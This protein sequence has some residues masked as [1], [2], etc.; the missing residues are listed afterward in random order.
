MWCLNRRNVLENFT[1]PASFPLS[2]RKSQKKKKKWERNSLSSSFNAHTITSI[3]K[4]SRH[5]KSNI[6]AITVISI[7]KGPLI[8]NQGIELKIL[9]LHCF[10]SLESHFVSFF[11][12]DFRARNSM[13]L[14]ECAGFCFRES[15][16]CPLLAT[17]SSGSLSVK[18]FNPS[19]TFCF[20]FFT[21]ARVLGW[22]AVFVWFLLPQGFDEFWWS[23]LL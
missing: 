6:A 3:W 15:V 16:Q 23:L 10:V 7:C 19:L 12:V 17:T 1:F 5:R 14:F 4:S 21:V 9:P 11:S 22:F 20:L 13:F 2:A 8:G 18:P